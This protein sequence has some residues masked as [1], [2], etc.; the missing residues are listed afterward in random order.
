MTEREQE[1]LLKLCGQQRNKIIKLETDNGRLR[2]KVIA[3]QQELNYVKT[4]QTN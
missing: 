4:R 2:R 1:K 3:L